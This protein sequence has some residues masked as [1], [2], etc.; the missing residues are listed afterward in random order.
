[1]ARDT[2][3][4]DVD[5]VNAPTLAK[6]LGVSRKQPAIWAEA[7]CPTNG[8]NPLTYSIP[9]VHAWLIERERA[10]FGDDLTETRRKKIDADWRKQE[11]AILE[12]AEELIPVMSVVTFFNQLLRTVRDIILAVPEKVVAKLPK[13]YQGPARAV[14]EEECRR[15]LLLCSRGAARYGVD[16]ME[17]ELLSPDQGTTDSKPSSRSRGKS[18]QNSTASSGRRKKSSSKRSVKRSPR[19]KR[20]SQASGQKD[21]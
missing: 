5:H 14:A 10:R 8:D 21:T 3:I 7:G 16:S 6:C 20:S 2:N 17:D 9:K 13:E 11:F 19:R 4:T 12:K 15:A 1:M 18:T